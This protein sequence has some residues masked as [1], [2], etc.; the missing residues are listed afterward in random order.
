VPDRAFPH[1]QNLSLIVIQAEFTS[2]SENE[3][4]CLSTIWKW[5]YCFAERR[6]ESCNDP[7]SRNPL[8]NEL[9]EIFAVMIQEWPFASC[10]IFSFHFRI[11]K[12]T[13]LY[14]LHDVLNLRKFHLCW[15]PQSQNTHPKVERITLSVKLLE[16][17]IT[18]QRKALKI[19]YWQ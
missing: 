17:L 5:H 8:C 1:S 18:K 2:A 6:T 15:M 4:L 9:D 11:T 10:K 14:I 13:C 3:A 16:V 19:F 7:R 12:Q